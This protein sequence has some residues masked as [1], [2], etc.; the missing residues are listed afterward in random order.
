MLA[1]GQLA[2]QKQVDLGDAVRFAVNQ[3]IIGLQ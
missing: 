1:W 3:L 2:M